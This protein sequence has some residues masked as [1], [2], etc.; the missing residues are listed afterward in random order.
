MQ[1]K[2]PLDED[3]AKIIN[4][5]CIKGALMIPCCIKM[6]KMILRWT[7]IS[8][9]ITEQR[10][11]EKDIPLDRVTDDISLGVLPGAQDLATLHTLLSRD[12]LI[13]PPQNKTA[14]E[15]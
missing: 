3:C 5:Q 2:T 7:E 11:S 4:P 14:K 8:K 6:K 1:D 12:L 10:E 13:L 15:K 9:M